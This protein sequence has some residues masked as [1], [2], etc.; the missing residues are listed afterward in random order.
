MVE[1]IAK[2]ANANRRHIQENVVHFFLSSN[3]MVHN[4]VNGPIAKLGLNSNSNFS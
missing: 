4:N 3:V 2:Q 1:E